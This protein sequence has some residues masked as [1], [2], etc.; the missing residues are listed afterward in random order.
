MGSLGIVSSS[1]LNG[2]LCQNRWFSLPRLPIPKLE[3]TCRRYLDA[4]KPLLT[5]EQYEQT[6]QVVEKFQKQEGQSPW[7]DMYLSYRDSIVLNHNPFMIIRATNL[8]KSAMR[9]KL[10]LDEKFLEPDIYHLKPEKSDTDWFK[11]IISQ[12]GRLFCS[13]RIPELKKDRLATYE[14]ARH[15]LVMRNGN[16]YVFDAINANDYMKT[17]TH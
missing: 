14:S 16:F 6:K 3:D 2:R 10:S 5:P 13:T 17:L 4:Q 12:Y 11:N 7:Y 1:A 9:F 8:I 15:M